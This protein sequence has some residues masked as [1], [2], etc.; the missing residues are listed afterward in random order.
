[1]TKLV[2]VAF[3]HTN[4]TATRLLLRHQTTQILSKKTIVISS[5]FQTNPSATTYQ[6]PYNTPSNQSIRSLRFSTQVSHDCPSC[7]RRDLI[8]RFKWLQLSQFSLQPPFLPRHDIS[9]TLYYGSTTTWRLSLQVCH[10][11]SDRTNIVP[12]DR[13]K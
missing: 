4:V 5:Y 7:I 6:D 2:V 12:A 13:S 1:M 10:C 3:P 8:D 11:H 9:D